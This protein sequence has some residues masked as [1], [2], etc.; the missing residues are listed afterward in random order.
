MANFSD[1]ELDDILR[2]MQDNK[3]T[4]FDFLNNIVKTENT[5]KVGNVSDDEIGMPKLPVRTN[6]E[7]EIFCRDVANMPDFGLYFNRMNEA[8]L[9]SSLSRKGFLVRAAITTKKELAD[10]SPERKV[11]KGWFKGGDDKDKNEELKI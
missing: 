6:Q 8:T 9:A 4:L 7:L 2:G 10:V 5:T 1:A 11:N 3:K